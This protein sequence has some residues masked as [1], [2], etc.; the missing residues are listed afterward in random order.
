MRK[1]GLVLKSV[2]YCCGM[3]DDESRTPEDSQNNT[4]VVPPRAYNRP[5]HRMHVGVFSAWHG[6][7]AAADSWWWYEYET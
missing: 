4:V 2:E 6:D 3:F 1:G 5:F 7:V